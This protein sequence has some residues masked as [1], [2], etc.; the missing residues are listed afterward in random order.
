M[1][2][3]AVLIVL[4]YGLLAALLTFVVWVLR[5]MMAAFPRAC[6]LDEREGMD[7]KKRQAVVTPSPVGRCVSRSNTKL[8]AE[9]AADKGST[10]GEPL[11]AGTRGAKSAQPPF[12]AIIRVTDAGNSALPLGAE[13]SVGG[14]VHIGRASSNDVVVEDTHVSRQ[15]AYLGR[16]GNG[17]VLV[18]KGSV[19]GTMVNG[20][21]VAGPFFLHHGDVISMGTVKFVFL[22]SGGLERGKA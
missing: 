13:F 16:R 2:L 11:S 6:A 7:R 5:E 19:N 15:H 9:A 20:Q 4:R 21:R 1:P 3:G 10:S 14:G 18:D 22:C 12:A 17:W 8:V